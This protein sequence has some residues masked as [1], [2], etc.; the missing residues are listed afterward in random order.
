ML[1]GGV[2]LVSTY[3]IQRSGDLANEAVEGCAYIE[4]MGRSRVE[5]PDPALGKGP[6]FIFH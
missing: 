4:V 2:A 1:L 3:V 6:F 5:L